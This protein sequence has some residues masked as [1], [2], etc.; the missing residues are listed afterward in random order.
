[1]KTLSLFLV[2][3]TIAASGCSKSNPSA[4]LES[5]TPIWTLGNF[6]G[7][8]TTMLSVCFPSS[9]IAYACGFRGLILKST[10]GGSTWN[11]LTSGTTQSLYQIAF[12][13]T[14]NGCVAGNNG[15]FLQTNDGG[16]NWNSTPFTFSHMNFRDLYYDQQKHIIGVGGTDDGTGWIFTSSD[17]GK[18]WNNYGT[19]SALYGIGWQHD[20]L[21]NDFTVVGVGSF[22]LWTSNFGIYWGAGYPNTNANFYGL[23]FSD[24]DNGMGVTDGGFVMKTTDGA[25]TWKQGAM[26]TPPIALR[27]IKLLSGS[28]ALVAG[29]KG[30][31]LRSTNGGTTWDSLSRVFSGNWNR[32]VERDRTHIA[33]VGDSGTL[34]W[35]N[36]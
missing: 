28:E 11:T 12:R 17:D 22:S 29:A 13:D 18:T 33:F 30:I 20:A 19:S 8:N 32:I 14:L 23:D 27:A 34:Y 7:T 26:I 35:L 4:P 3:L 25:K 21:Q 2:I 16:L 36:P 9:T 1:M 24:H 5:P 6:G 15:T 31:V 10:D